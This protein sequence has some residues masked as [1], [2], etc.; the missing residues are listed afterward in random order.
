MK[1]LITSLIFILLSSSAFGNPWEDALNC[2]DDVFGECIP[3]RATNHEYKDEVSG[4]LNDF[5]K[6]LNQKGDGVINTS[7]NTGWYFHQI[8]LRIRTF[9]KY[10]VPLLAS[11]KV[12]PH[13][14]FF[15][16]RKPPQGWSPYKP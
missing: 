3:Q 8:R 15:W 7:S 13:L 12:I 4:L 16:T 5:D 2:E 1:I 9:A 10:S 11:I 14:E 6:V